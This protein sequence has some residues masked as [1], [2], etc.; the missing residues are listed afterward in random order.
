[1]KITINDFSID[2]RLSAVLIFLL[3]IALGYTEQFFVLYI[4]MIIHELIHIL[5]AH[6]LGCKCKGIVIMPI[7]LQGKIEELENKP[8][9]KRNIIIGAAS[10]F[11][12]IAGIIINRSYIGIG[13][14]LIGIFNLLPI[15][16]LDGAMLFRNM[17]GYFLG[18]LKAE[19]YV[20][21]LSSFF[22]AILFFIGIIWLVLFDFSFFPLII[23]VYLYKESRKIYFV[24]AFYFYK[25]LFKN[26]STALNKI[27]FRK[28]CENTTLK[29]LLY[30]FGIDYYTMIY[31]N[32]KIIDE[33]KIKFYICKYG[34]NITIGDILNNFSL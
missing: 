19:K 31:V 26:K 21:I 24:K 12:I 8:L 14:I 1:M 17:A 6:F 9:Y 30:S 7:G 2:V 18:T 33:D 13:N 25:G 22:I 3:M 34:L 32:G 27:R 10:L 11:N 28:Y 5:T 15:Y 4:F 16:P 23:S 20:G 29:E